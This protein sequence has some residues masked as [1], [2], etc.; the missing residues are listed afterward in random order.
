MLNNTRHIN[1]AAVTHKIQTG[2]GQ[3]KNRRRASPILVH[4]RLIRDLWS[5][6]EQ[7]RSRIYQPCWVS[8]DFHS[9]VVRWIKT[10]YFLTHGAKI[11]NEFYPPEW[12]GCIYCAENLQKQTKS[13]RCFNLYQASPLIYMS[14]ILNLRQA[15]ASA[16]SVTSL[17][18]DVCQ[19]ENENADSPG[20]VVLDW[21]SSSN[22]WT[23]A[24]LKIMWP[25]KV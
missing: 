16:A 3:E 20:W 10:D 21:D 11:G 8:W 13:S 1:D 15:D 22:C 23:W 12:F 18:N 6:F 2:R 24:E 14:Q 7:G 5:M 17:F 9:R 4:L 25:S 19:S